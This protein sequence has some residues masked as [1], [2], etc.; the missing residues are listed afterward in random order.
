MPITG[1]GHAKWH[2][3]HIDFNKRI[4]YLPPF[5]CPFLKMDMLCYIDFNKRIKYLPPFSRPFPKMDMLCTTLCYIDFNKRINQVQPVSHWFLQKGKLITTFLCA[6]AKFRKA[7]ISLAM[8]VRPSVRM[9]QLN[10]H[11]T[12]FHEIWYLHIFR[13]PVE[14][15]QGSLKS[16]KNNGYFTWRPIYIFDHI[17]LS[18][19]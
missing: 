10:S 9:K 15:I 13:K 8:S 12:D 7:I 17:S 11:W 6:F 14:K 2:V 19:S 3:F 1:K 5:S 16:N 18:S 4:K